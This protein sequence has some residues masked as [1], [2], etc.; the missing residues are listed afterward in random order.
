VDSEFWR[1]RR[2]DSVDWTDAPR[3]QFINLVSGHPPAGYERVVLDR[4]SAPEA[5]TQRIQALED[6][7]GERRARA[8]ALLAPAGPRGEPALLEVTPRLAKRTK[9]VRKLV[10]TDGEYTWGSGLVTETT[11]YGQPIIP[12]V[13]QLISMLD[14]KTTVGA[15]VRKMRASVPRE[16]HGELQRS[17]L[18]TVVDYYANGAIESL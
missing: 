9:V 3:Q 15:A 11:P 13:A 16:H 10:L 2:V 12:P 1:A 18:Q 17:V 14:G 6:A 4:G 8:V 5:F 7:Q